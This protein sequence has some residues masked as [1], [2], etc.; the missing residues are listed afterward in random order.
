MKI[1]SFTMV[2]NES[3]IIESF[4]RYNHNFVDEMVIIDN[5]CTDSTIRI[6]NSLVNEGFN[7]TVYDESLEAYN[8]FRL[9]NKYIEKI[10]N[11][12]NP[13]II[14]PLD[15]DEFLT[16]E[17]NPRLILESLSLE[18]IYYVNWKWYVMSNKD[19]LDE[20]FI[21]NRMQ[22]RLRKT[23]WNY[24]D[25]TSVTKTIIPAKYYKRMGLKL[26]MGHHTVYGNEKVEIIQLDDLVLAH[27][28]AISEQQLIYKTSCYTIRDIAT[29][30]NNFETAQRTNHMAL[31][32]AGVD[33]WAASEEASYG[34]Y[35]R[36]IVHDPL[37]LEFCDNSTSIMKYTTFSKESLAKRLLN[38]GREMAIKVYNVERERKEKVL[39]QPIILWL[40]GV[41]GEECIFPDPSN[42]ITILTELYNVRGLLT[43]NEEIKFLKANYRLIVTSDFIKF[44][45]HQYIVIPNTVDIN[46]VRQQL[47]ELGIDGSKI[48]SERGY[49]KELGL[50]LRCYCAVRF[51]PSM[52]KRI[53]SYISRNGIRSTTRK[54]KDR[55]KN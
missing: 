47:I 19:E 25:G 5:G 38:T 43:T 36:D 48:I 12:K 21:P 30:E 11:E 22:Y 31:I 14:L 42:R 53:Y 33:M 4:I 50:F 23:A 7:I 15:A 28:R 52:S 45:P 51:I 18:K 24:S 13:D 9:D 27:Y 1:V 17:R 6:I 34:G 2:N 55:L 41:R 26:S 46:E 35:S 54:I 8:Q 37:S 10:I 39:L 49:Q 32:E 40:D 29:M 16:S 20:S 44:L 3:E